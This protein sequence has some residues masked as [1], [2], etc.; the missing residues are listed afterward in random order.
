MNGKNLFL[1]NANGL[2]NVQTSGSSYSNKVTVA[3][4]GNVTIAD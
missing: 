3:E 2:F 1:Q 4:N